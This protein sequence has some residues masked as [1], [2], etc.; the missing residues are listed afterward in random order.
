MGRTDKEAIDLGV[1]EILEPDQ[2]SRSWQK[3]SNG[4]HSHEKPILSL[5]HRPPP[6]PLSPCLECCYNSWPL[7]QA[8]VPLLTRSLFSEVTSTGKLSW[9]SPA[10]SLMLLSAMFRLFVTIISSPIVCLVGLWTP[11]SQWWGA[12]QLCPPSPRA[13]EPSK[14]LTNGG[15]CAGSQEP[16]KKI[17][18]WSQQRRPVLHEFLPFIFLDSRRFHLPV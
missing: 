7:L 12:L 18:I 15:N 1:S 8:S 16:L 5:F 14:G 17:K 2:D 13:Q 11:S 4:Q 10:P 3:V 9:I 6:V